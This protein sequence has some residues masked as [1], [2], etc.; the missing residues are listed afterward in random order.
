MESHWNVENGTHMNVRSP[1]VGHPEGVWVAHFLRLFILEDSKSNDLIY[2]NGTNSLTNTVGLFDHTVGDR[3]NGN[4]RVGVLACKAGER[5]VP[6]IFAPFC[7]C[8]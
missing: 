5:G 4:G 1:L 2:G 3:N 7:Q 8:V 6:T